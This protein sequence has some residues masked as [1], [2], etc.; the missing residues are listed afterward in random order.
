MNRLMSS[1]LM[2]TRAV[3]QKRFGRS[4]HNTFWRQFT[5]TGQSASDLIYRALVD[6]HPALISRFGSGELHAVATYLRKQVPRRFTGQKSIRYILGKIDTFWWHDG[7]RMSVSNGAGMFSNDDPG[8]DL[9]SRTVLQDCQEIDILGSWRD[10]ES[11]IDPFIGE[12]TAVPLQDLEPY[13]NGPPY[14]T[15]ALRGKNVLVIHPFISSIKKQYEKRRLLYSSQDLLPD[16]NLT[17]YKPVQTLAGLRDDRFAEWCDALAFMQDE[18]N[19]LEF[20]IAIIGAGSYGLSLGA[21]IRRLGKKAVHLGG[22]TQILF[23]IRGK[24][25]DQSPF[26]QDIYNDHWIYPEAAER[27]PSADSVE[28]GCYW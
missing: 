23:G 9:F 20:D 7:I 8:L 5:C 22:A 1:V 26:F 16:F 18:I 12:Y 15:A 6:H 2:R 3:V 14:W 28:N 21:Y 13:Y 19:D 24:R 27:P 17:G 11:L 4:E 25:W 10:E